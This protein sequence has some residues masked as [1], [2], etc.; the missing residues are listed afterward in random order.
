MNMQKTAT[1]AGMT[2]I[3]LTEPLAAERP[4][5]GAPALAATFENPHALLQACHDRVLRMADLLDR[6]TA[7]VRTH[8]ADAQARQAATDVLRYFD[9]AA[10]HHH[11]DEERHVIPVLLASG[12]AQHMACARILLDEHATMSAQWHTLRPA[13]QALADVAASAQAAADWL[14]MHEAVAAFTALY[15]QHVTLEENTAYP[16]AFALLS[17]RAIEHM[18]TEM[19]VRRGAQA[20]GAPQGRTDNE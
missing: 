13:L 11:E 19:A 4:V 20:I 7:H 9:L 5:P 6:L 8:G 16:A 15:R 18:G 17:A 1:M 3:S 10:P 2:L 12:N 14:G